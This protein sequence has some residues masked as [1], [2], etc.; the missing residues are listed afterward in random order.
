M[1]AERARRKVLIV[2]DSPTTRAVLKVYLVGH[3]LEFI[4]AADGQAGLAQAKAVQPDVIVLDLRLPKL[5]GFSVC[6][7][8]RLDPKLRR[9]PII[10]VT[11]SKDEAVRAE[12]MRAGAT[13]FLAK[14]IDGP[15]LAAHI[16]SCLDG[17]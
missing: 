7:A 17:K 10:L 8:V 9:T 4:E 1:T 14:P 11:G 12:A 5:D 15:Q 3:D 13:H 16:L 6:R 2:E